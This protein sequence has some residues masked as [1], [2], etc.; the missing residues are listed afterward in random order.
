[1][2]DLSNC[3]RAIR[4]QAQACVVFGSAFSGAV[5]ERAADDLEQ[6]GPTAAI[7]APWADATTRALMSDAVPIRLLGA[8]HDVALSGEAPALSAA[9]P[10]SDR[11]GD[12]DAAW[13]EARAVIADR[14]HRISTFM[15][16]EPQTNEVRR[17]AWLIGGFLTI[18]AETGLP[19]RCFE[20]GASAGL[21]QLWDRFF[22]RLGD[23][24]A[25]GD[26]ASS[27]VIDTDWRG[28]A[29][30]I[31]APVRVIERAAC[32][33]APIDLAGEIARRRLR[34]YVWADQIDRMRR[35]EAAIALGLAE[36]VRVDRDDAVA[37][38]QA[39]AHPRE[40]AATVLYHSVFWQYL[41]ARSQAALTDAIR[42]HG[43][44]AEANAPFAWLRME[45]RPNDLAT[46][47]LRLTLWPRGEERVLAL[48]HPHGA[49]VTWGE[50][51]TP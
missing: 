37:W 28:R 46:M 23:V 6:G 3:A 41:P 1:M 40:G 5:L 32:D 18:A 2:S 42:A 47:D 16:H 15:A 50:A 8:L 38:T 7:L 49:E 22:Y 43:A 29:P 13:T 27:V 31:D 12:V 24:A 36:G 10:A 51:M 33:R 35:L 34:A 26:P 48:V 45:P 14:P 9:Y 21:N 4:L 19:L 17:S 20:V 44:R 25:W 11:S 30:P 39:R